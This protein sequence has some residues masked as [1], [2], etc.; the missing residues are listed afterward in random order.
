MIGAS[1]SNNVTAS[2]GGGV[3]GNNGSVT[4]M[5]STLTNNTASHVGGG[6][7]NSSAL[8]LTDVT[9]NGNSASTDGGGIYNNNPGTAA[10]TNVTLSNNS[11]GEGGGIYTFAG[12]MTLNNITFARNAAVYGAGLELF[13]GTHTLTNVTFSG[14]SAS[15]S[16]GGI[17]NARA[18]LTVINVTLAGN[19]S[20]TGETGGIENIGGGPDP[21]LNLKNV[22]LA[23]G[24]AGSNC[25]FSILPDSS[26][27]N[28]SSDNSCS[29]GSGRDNVNVMLAPLGNY[30]GSTQT[31]IPLPGSPAIDFG[32]NTG[33]PSTDQRGLPRPIG[34]ACDVGAVERQVI[35]FSAFLFL[36]LIER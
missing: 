12:A 35:D 32:T 9:L 19:S 27:F 22:L 14:N 33:C 15:T 2:E 29:F 10:L 6:I 5:Q 13:L 36:P 28:L 34:L 1:I 16:G 3:H 26:A 8:T 18:T 20:A 30:G 21:H 4:I 11:A 7:Y 25:G 17:Y 23:A 31:H 24:A